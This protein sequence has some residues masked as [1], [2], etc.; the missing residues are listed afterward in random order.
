MEDTNLTALYEFHQ[1]YQLRRQAIEQRLR[2]DVE[3]FRNELNKLNP[4]SRSDVE[5]WNF[6]IYQQLVQRRNRL[7][8]I[9]FEQAD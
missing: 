5:R 8:R 4:D 1:G 6:G 2:G 7:L 9:L 3:L